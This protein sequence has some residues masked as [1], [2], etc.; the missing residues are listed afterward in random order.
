MTGSCAGGVPYVPP[1]PLPS[2]GWCSR[3]GFVDAGT[4]LFGV[5]AG[6]AGVAVVVAGTAGIEAA[7]AALS[8]AQT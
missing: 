3:S 1:P 5:A 4:A 2:C 6:R 8:T 7:E